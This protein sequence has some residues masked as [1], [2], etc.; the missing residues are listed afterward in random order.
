MDTIEEKIVRVKHIG[1]IYKEEIDIFKS[2]ENIIKKQLLLIIDRFAGNYDLISSN[3]VRTLKYYKIISRVK[4]PDSFNEKLVRN[5]LLNEFSNCFKVAPYNDLDI[6]NKISELDDIIGIKILTD[7]NIDSVNMFFL[8][9][10]TEFQSTAKQDGFQFNEDD[11][12]LQPTKMKNGLSI[13]KIRCVF[14]GDKFE[15]QIKSKLE[16]SWGDMEHSIFYK[17]YRITPVRSFAQASMNHVGELLLKIDSFLYDIRKANESFEA[18]SEVVLFMNSFEKDYSDI[19]RKKLD[20]VSYNFTKTTN[21]AYFI[22]KN[23]LEYKPEYFDTNYQKLECKRYQKYIDLRNK[24]FD[25]QILEGIVLTSIDNN[26]TEENIGALLDEF[27]KLLKDA[28]IKY[29]LSR[30]NIQDEESLSLYINIIISSCLEYDCDKYILETHEVEKLLQYFIIV[31]DSLDSIDLEEDRLI[32][33][34]TSIS[35]L[36]FSGDIDAYL[37]TIPNKEIFKENLEISKNNI[38]KSSTEFSVISN[39]IGI[40]IEK[41]D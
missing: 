36:F 28:N 8:I 22:S 9:K 34:L 41:N 2:K 40:L 20:G 3:S 17:D 32:E 16:S 26:I 35:I 37:Q 12:S 15:L 7:L 18:N 23:E 4:E 5:N 24:N 29:N 38:Y 6:K 14:R 13:Y 27:F 10:S 11:L 30:G 31:K 39:L 25:L 1:N 33:I 21:I 19:V